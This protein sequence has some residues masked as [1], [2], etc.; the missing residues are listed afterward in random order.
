MGRQGKERQKEG[1]RIEK[2]R[3]AY[4][5]TDVLLTPSNISFLCCPHL[6]PSHH[7]P[8]CDVSE[9]LPN[10]LLFLRPLKF[11]SVSHT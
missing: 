9:E 11:L 5:A 4:R 8:A 7:Q 10:T 6:G 1:E 2:E 3:N